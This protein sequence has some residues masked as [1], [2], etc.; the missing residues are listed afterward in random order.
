ME[1]H[2]APPPKV[3][4]EQT[5][6]AGASAY[7]LVPKLKVQIDSQNAHVSDALKLIITDGAGTLEQHGRRA[8]LSASRFTWLDPA[9]PHRLSIRE[10]RLLIVRF[11]RTQ[12]RRLHPMLEVT[13]AIARGAST[14]EA[15]A[16]RLFTE[17]LSAGLKLSADQQYAAAQSVIASLGLCT[18]KSKSSRRDRHVALA[19]ADINASL[20]DPSLQA[21]SVAERRGT[22]RRYLDRAFS[23][24]LG[25][26][27]AEFIRQQRLDGA[28]AELIS[29]GSSQVGELGRRWGFDD[30]SH[31]G[32]AFRHQFGCSP[33]S[34]TRRARRLR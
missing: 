12:L 21:A 29:T 30:A 17:V 23:T 7:W 33:G 9:A 1:L 19:V 34:V 11:T 20:R 31:F 5:H 24:V 27:V 16:S 15:V 3:I 32:R 26:T 14:P 2:V 18:Q 25:M 28:A 6:V 13:T 10:G 8:E 22:S 4:A